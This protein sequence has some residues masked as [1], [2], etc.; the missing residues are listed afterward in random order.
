MMNTIHWDSLYQT[1][2]FEIFQNI[3]NVIIYFNTLFF[4]QWDLFLG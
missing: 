4:L 2:L 1:L 3:K